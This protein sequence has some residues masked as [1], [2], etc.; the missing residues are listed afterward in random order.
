MTFLIATF[1]SISYCAQLLPVLKALIIGALRVM[2]APHK[3]FVP[4]GSAA[5]GVLAGNVAR[6]RLVGHAT[7]LQVILSYLSL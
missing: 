4:S 3:S 5:V 2:S 1:S 7:T 6:S